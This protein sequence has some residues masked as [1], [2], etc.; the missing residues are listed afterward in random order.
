MD[1]SPL[2]GG[3]GGPEGRDQAFFSEISEHDIE[4]LRQREE[5]LV[6]IEVSTPT[7]P[8]SS[9]QSSEN[10]YLSIGLSVCLVISLKRFTK[11]FPSSYGEALCQINQSNQKQSHFP[12]SIGPQKF[13]TSQTKDLRCFLQFK[14]KVKVEISHEYSESLLIQQWC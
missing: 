12:S 1:D 3:A 10:I 7:L 8:L 6:Q 5:A 13:R 4:V 11:C 9:T 2:F 14:E